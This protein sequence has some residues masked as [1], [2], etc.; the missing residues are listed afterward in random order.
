MDLFYFEM[1]K[2]YIYPLKKISEDLQLDF[3]NKIKKE[4]LDLGFENN[5][6]QIEKK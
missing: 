2:K 4:L 6:F 1:D 3:L 5:D